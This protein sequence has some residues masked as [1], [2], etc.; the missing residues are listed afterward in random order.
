M[1]RLKVVSIVLL[2]NLLV[3]NTFSQTKTDKVLRP[4][5]KGIINF[6]AED[7]SWSAKMTLRFQT[8]FSSGYNVSHNLGLTDN[9]SNFM[10]RRA[11]LKFSGHAFSPK[12]RYKMELGQSSRD[13]GGFIDDEF[14]NAPGLVFDAV[15][16]WN[17][18]KGF[19]LWIGQTKLPGNRERVIS[20]GSLQLVDRSLLNSRFN[21]DRDMGV[22]LHHKWSTGNPMKSFVM[23]EKLSIS[24]GEGRGIVINNVGG[25]SYTGRLEFLPFGEF[26]SK[27]KDD[28]TSSSLKRVKTSKL[29]LA[30]GGDFNHN[31]ARTFAS[32]GFFM[33]NDSDE[34]YFTTD[35]TTIFI[36]LMYKLKGWSLMAEYADRKAQD[37][38]AKNLDGTPTGAIVMEGNSL[39]V[40]AGH[41]FKSNWEI[42]GRFTYVDY[43]N[44][45]TINK[46]VFDENQYTLGVSKYFAGHNLKLQADVSYKDTDTK[47]GGILGRIQIELQL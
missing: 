35:I 10:I 8:L 22:Q 42:T 13:I 11:R 38:I 40:M 30:V 26:D 6:T 23:K 44:R 29:V 9:F 18:A 15:I 19:D 41:L 43:A 24:Q 46:G 7:N 28:Y 20:S 21:I 25:L 32:R 1:S 37:P 12:V 36:D 17:F 45:Y 16:F 34:G 31:A 33:E 5:G 39:N 14:K 3:I 4:F 2:F 27:G 47:D